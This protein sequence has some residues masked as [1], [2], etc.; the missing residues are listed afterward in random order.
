M[1]NLRL[2]PFIAVEP[3]MRVNINPSGQSDS[4]HYTHPRLS[5][6]LPVRCMRRVPCGVS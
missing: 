5:P 3:H 2:G 4:R 6:P 1:K